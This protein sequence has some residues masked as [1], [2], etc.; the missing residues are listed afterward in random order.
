MTRRKAPYYRVMTCHHLINFCGAWALAQGIE[1]LVDSTHFQYSTVQRPRD[2][3]PLLQ[4]LVLQL[5]IS[6]LWSAREFIH[7][8]QEPFS[9][10]HVSYHV[11]HNRRPIDSAFLP[12]SSTTSKCLQSHSQGILENFCSTYQVRSCLV[13]DR[14]PTLPHI[15]RQI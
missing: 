9:R 13:P 3:S 5:H 8:P 11:P 6:W 12:S 10:H 15:P 14:R 7:V 4:H 1:L 2:H